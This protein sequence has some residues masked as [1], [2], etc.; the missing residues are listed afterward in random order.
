MT[1][2]SGITRPLEWRKQQLR[3]MARLLQENK[4]A[5]EHAVW[6]DLGK[7][8]I[9]A[10]ISE[11]FGIVKCCQMGLDDLDQWAAPTKPPVHPSHNTW[12]ATIHAVPK[13][14]VLIIA[15]VR[16]SEATRSY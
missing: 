16:L 2:N 13:G 9:E 12:N 15:F 3:Q 11:V 10:A 4:K 8:P 6:Q 7:P 5:V 14:V 1:F